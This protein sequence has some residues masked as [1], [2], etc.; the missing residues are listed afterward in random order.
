[1]LLYDTEPTDYWFG[2]GTHRSAP[3]FTSPKLTTA[4]FGTHSMKKGRHVTEKVTNGVGATAAAD[5]ACAPDTIG[6][7]QACDLIVFDH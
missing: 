4:D 7:R 6:G 2:V 3:E 1:M 5:G